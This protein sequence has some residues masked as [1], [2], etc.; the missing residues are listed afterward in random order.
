MFD[1]KIK[2]R[3]EKSKAR[4]GKIVTPNGEIGTLA[5]I[6]CATKRFIRGL[7]GEQLKDSKIQII[8]SNTYHLENISRK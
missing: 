3:C 2:R 1:F 7:T 5:F 4:V 8:L 6:F